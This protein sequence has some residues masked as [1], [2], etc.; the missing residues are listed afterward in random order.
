VNRRQFG[1]TVPPAPT[2]ALV[3]RTIHRYDGTAKKWEVAEI[4]TEGRYEPTEGDGGE[5]QDGEFFNDLT[6]Q[7]GGTIDEVRAG[8]DDEVRAG[9]DQMMF[10]GSLKWAAGC[11]SGAWHARGPR[12]GLSGLA[13][14]VAVVVSE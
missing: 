9:L 14:Q 6:G 7:F 4:G 11:S 8:L 10:A 5:F 12:G 3:R 1:D 2:P 13:A